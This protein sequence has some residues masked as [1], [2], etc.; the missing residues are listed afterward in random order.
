[1]IPAFTKHRSS[2]SSTLSLL[3]FDGTNGSTSFVDAAPNTTWS[4][5]GS[6]VIST[7]QSMFGGS[8]LYLN[9]SSFLAAATPINIDLSQTDFTIE[10]FIYPTSISSTWVFFASWAGVSNM[11]L[12]AFSGAGSDTRL[13]YNQNSTA[14]DSASGVI[15]A[16]AWQH[17]AWVRKGQNVYGFVGGVLE[18]SG[19]I[20]AA[21]ST[22]GYAAEI[23]RNN[24]N[25]V[26][27]YTGYIDEFRL[28]N[29]ARYTA[30]FTPPTSPFTYP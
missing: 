24:Q 12:R 15:V 27:Y 29:V 2:A 21:Q 8:S 3:H 18:A 1:M 10:G 17:V 5:T 30:N 19:T 22:A 9:G 20:T 13:D 25:N 11:V 28:S 16:N 6:P 7:A 4:G 26:W 14:F 23:G